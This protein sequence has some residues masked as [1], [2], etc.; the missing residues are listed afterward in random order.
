MTTSPMAVVCNTAIVMCCFNS[1]ILAP[2]LARD[3]G[4][5]SKGPI[6]MDFILGPCPSRTPT[7]PAS[8]A[9]RV[10]GSARAPIPATWLSSAGFVSSTGSAR[11]CRPT[12]P[13]ANVHRP[14]GNW[15][16]TCTCTASPAGGRQ[17]TASGRTRAP[18][19]PAK[20]TRPLPQRPESPDQRPR[21][22]PSHRP[23]DGQRGW[24][25]TP[26]PDRTDPDPWPQRPGKPSPWDRRCYRH[27]GE[28]RAGGLP[29]SEPLHRESF[30]LRTG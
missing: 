8:V 11:R 17:C 22:L 20:R 19:Q 7:G 16:P 4:S 28:F 25:E 24:A 9:R 29:S 3:E 15:W 27:R 12:R 13:H 1:L 21:P 6:V 18:P 14:S 2:G 30:A 5:F 26:T 10:P 23:G